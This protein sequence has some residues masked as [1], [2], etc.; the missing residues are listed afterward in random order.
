MRGVN[1]L[2]A[3]RCI[4]LGVSR[5][6][7]PLSL[8]SVTVENR[9]V[10]SA[11]AEG[12][13]D[14]EGVPSPLLAR[15]YERWARGGVG[16]AITGMAY[17]VRGHGFTGHEIGLADDRAIDAL[18]EVTGRVH[19]AGG[20]IVAQL[21]HADPQIRRAVVL[22]QGAIAPSGGLSR[23]HFHY[24]RTASDAEI[25]AMIDAFGAAAA[26]AVR[27]GFD[28][29][30]LHAAHG[31]FLSRSISSRYNRRRD[32]WGGSEEKRSAVLVESVRAVRR[33]VG[34]GV[35]VLVKLNAHD[36]FA[37]GG[38]QLEES[39]RLGRRLQD[40]SVDAIEVS[41]GTAD[42]GMGI[43][44]NRGGMPFDIGR[45]YLAEEFPFMRPILPFLPWIARFVER[46]VAFREEAYFAPLAERFARALDIPVICVGGVRSREVAERLLDRGV[47]MVSLARPLVRQP[48]LPRAW[49]RGR[50]DKAQCISCNR[51]FVELG[52]E[53]PL[54][55]WQRDKTMRPRHEAR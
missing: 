5:L 10:K 12:A 9:I 25:R 1:D 47:A 33:A 52:L 6:F 20:R 17:V 45:T 27:A 29:V 53:Q 35:P 43:Y 14:A 24:N 38:L 26:R 31:Y 11:M 21:C 18:R 39:V 46:S 8:R 19:A 22:R 15:M 37:R 36:G 23:T 13:C 3:G 16:L 30:Q 55:C 32:R 7:T 48:A 49:Q 34:E 28:G 2:R 42:V 41:A 44:P 54:R 40:A 51:C 4:L 50:E